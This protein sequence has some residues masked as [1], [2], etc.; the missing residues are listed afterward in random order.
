MP[1]VRQDVPEGLTAGLD[2]FQDR[3]LRLERIRADRIRPHPENWRTHPAEQGKALD[4][5]LRRI[6]FAAAV[7][8]REVEGDPDHAFELVDGHLRRQKSGKRK[9]P[10]L[11]VDLDEREARLVIA[12]FDRVTQMAGADPDA[13]GRILAQATW[14]ANEETGGLLE[15]LAAQTAPPDIVFPAY[16]LDVAGQVVYVT[17]PDCGHEFPR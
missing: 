11:V 6:G 15:R 10:A 2:L 16:D 13:L 7:I 9:I 3:I 12:T 8:V 4:W 1:E 17:C 14:K 5:I